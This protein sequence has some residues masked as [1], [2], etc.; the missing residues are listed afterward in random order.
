[1]ALGRQR[2]ALGRQRR[3]AIFEV[4]LLGVG[5]LAPGPGLAG[6]RMRICRGRFLID[7]GY[8]IVVGQELHE[9]FETVAAE[10]AIQFALGVATNAFAQ[11]ADQLRVVTTELFELTPV[12]GRLAVRGKRPK[13]G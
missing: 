4:A 13:T 1:M 8:A 10:L 2:I 5:I 9:V 7:T 11:P 12:E 6:R 3:K